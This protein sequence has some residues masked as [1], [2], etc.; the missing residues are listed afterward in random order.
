MTRAVPLVY[1][2]HYFYL[3]NKMQK[4]LKLIKRLQCNIINLSAVISV[5]KC[6]FSS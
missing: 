6:L 3:F 4:N 2:I 5:F 1:I